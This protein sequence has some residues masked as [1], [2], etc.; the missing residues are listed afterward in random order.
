MK[1]VIAAFTSLLISGCATP[2]T[3]PSEACVAL[4]AGQENV[5]A[6]TEISDR[7][8]KAYEKN[9]NNKNLIANAEAAA[10]AAQAA[11]DLAVVEA[12]CQASR[13]AP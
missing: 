7:A 3:V 2:G 12:D 4:A 11:A 13:S 10:N 8:S 6:L 1:I 5:R 9:R